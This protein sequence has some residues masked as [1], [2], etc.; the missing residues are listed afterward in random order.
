[1]ADPSGGPAIPTAELGLAAHP[2]D[3]GEDAADEREGSDLR[4]HEDPGAGGVRVEAEAVNQRA[5]RLARLPGGLLGGRRDVLLDLLDDRTVH[6]LHI[7]LWSVGFHL[8]KT[9]LPAAFARSSLRAV[10]LPGQHHLP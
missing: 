7:H 6:C 10:Q 9:A 8:T 3:G 2:A 4:T 5:R 1:M